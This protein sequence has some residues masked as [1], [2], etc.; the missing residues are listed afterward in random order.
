[1]KRQYC[2]IIYQANCR[3]R[4]FVAKQRPQESLIIQMFVPCCVIVIAVQDFSA[5]VN[6]HLGFYLIL[7]HA[8]TFG[9]RPARATESVTTCDTEMS[10]FSR[11]FDNT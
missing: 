1:M 4:H 8:H 3:Y 9:T 10:R 5:P 7:R 11:L 6:P 2:S